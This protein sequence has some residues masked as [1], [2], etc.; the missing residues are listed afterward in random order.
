MTEAERE[1]RRKLIE[2]DE[3]LAQMRQFQDL[4]HLKLGIWLRSGPSPALRREIEEAAENYGEAFKRVM[5]SARPMIT[6]PKRG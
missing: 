1:H 6:G 2:Q 4:I 5:D 3:Q